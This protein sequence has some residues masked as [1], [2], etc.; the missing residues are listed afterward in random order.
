M[1][2]HCLTLLLSIILCYICTAKVHAQEGEFRLPTDPS[3]WLNSPPISLEILEGK[4][5]MLYFFEES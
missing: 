4:A 3:V 1:R 2:K 5:A